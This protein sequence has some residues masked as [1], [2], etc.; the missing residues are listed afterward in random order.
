MLRPTRSVVQASREATWE[1]VAEDAHRI[2]A[3]RARE[4]ARDM[5]IMAFVAGFLGGLLACVLVEVLS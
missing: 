2:V 5:L 3:A 4:T 1:T